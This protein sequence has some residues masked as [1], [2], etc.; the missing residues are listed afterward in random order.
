MLLFVYRFI[1]LFIL[2][3]YCLFRKS[4]LDIRIWFILSI[5]ICKFYS[6]HLWLYELDP[7]FVCIRLQ[8]NLIYW[9]LLN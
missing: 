6:E 8:A 7:W 1:Y 2:F 9:S 3:I 4:L 5:Y